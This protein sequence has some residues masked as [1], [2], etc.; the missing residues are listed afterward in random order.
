MD[1]GIRVSRSNCG[2]V[3]DAVQLVTHHAKHG[4]NLQPGDLLGS[5]RCPGLM[6]KNLDACWSLLAMGAHLFS[7]TSESAWFS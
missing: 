5:G 3:L 4:C 2:P 6:T 1:E 7:L